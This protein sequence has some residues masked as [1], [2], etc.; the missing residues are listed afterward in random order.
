MPLMMGVTTTS[1]LG[2]SWFTCMRGDWPSLHILPEMTTL[3]LLQRRL[4]FGSCKTHSSW[5]F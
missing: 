4:R 3:R 1:A 5:S 2:N